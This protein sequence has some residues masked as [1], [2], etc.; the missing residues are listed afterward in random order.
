MTAL[1]RRLHNEEP[2]NL[3]AL[4][5]IIWVIKSRRVRGVGHV[6]YVG[7]MRNSYNTI[8]GL[9]NLKGRDHLED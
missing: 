3:Y 8:F 1:W 9:E 7:E 2:G 6:A 4:P 5:N